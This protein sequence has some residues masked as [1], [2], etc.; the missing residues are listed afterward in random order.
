MTVQSIVFFKEKNV[1]QS[2]LQLD[3]KEAKRLK[4]F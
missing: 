4:K 3:E 2:K 1:T